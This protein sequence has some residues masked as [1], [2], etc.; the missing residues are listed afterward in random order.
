MSTD[1]AQAWP[2]ISLISAQT[3]SSFA[4]LRPQPTTVAPSRASSTEAAR[5]SPEP[6]PETMQTLPFSRPGRKMSD[7]GLRA[8]S[9]GSFC[10]GVSEN[11]EGVG[12][13][14]IAVAV[15][16]VHRRGDEMTGPDA[17]ALL[18]G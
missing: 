12:R 15:Q 13:H 1:R 14:P 17:R 10:R 18:R 11:G 5:P 7:S 2:P 9:A 8:T 16:E 3:E 6:N 4:V